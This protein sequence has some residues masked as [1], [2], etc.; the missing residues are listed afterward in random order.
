M[1]DEVADELAKCAMSVDALGLS[2]WRPALAGVRV[3]GVGAAA[4]GARELLAMG[5]HLVEYAVEDL[6]ARV[7]VLGASEAGATVVDEAVRGIGAP[8]EAV[9]SLGGWEYD[10]R[11]VVDLVSW[12]RDHNEMR[13]PADRVRVVGADPVRGAASVKAL[14]AYLR[15]TAPELLPDARESLAELLDR[16]PDARAV[17][18]RVR[19]DVVGLHGRMVADETGLVA[20]S[21]PD[22]YAEACRHARI[23]ARIAEVACAPRVPAPDGEAQAEALP[24]GSASVL[25]ARLVAEAVERAADGVEGTPAVV[26]WG[27][28]DQ[29]RVGDPTTAGRYLR[30]DLG[31]AYYAVA[32]LFGEGSASAVRRRLLGAVRPRPT[33]NRLPRLPDSL[34]SDLGTALGD[35]GERLVDLR[36]AQDDGGPVARWA[37]APTTTRR[38]RS[39]VDSRQL[40]GRTPVVP[41]Q[42]FDALALVPRVHPAWIR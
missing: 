1:D 27:H 6:G 41:D 14:A 16:D 35:D 21:S 30:A 42:E 38:L 34:E 3:L 15:A 23:L 33:T 36:G 25:R 7:V 31:E 11:E 4:H 2:P 18:A 19:D 37:G 39:V 8:G 5:R 26:F 20:Q 22:R 12:L 29:I 17:P 10:T 40:R 13:P 32:G 28:D 24:S 9:A